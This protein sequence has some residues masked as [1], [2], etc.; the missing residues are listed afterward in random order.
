[1]GAVTV[2][3]LQ[4]NT[5]DLNVVANPITFGKK[6]NIDVSSGDGIYGGLAASWTVTN[7]GSIQ[8]VT[9]GVDLAS[10]GS[11]LTNTGA[12]AG[13]GTQ[14]RGLTTQACV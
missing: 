1:M 6:T 11:T 2:N 5:Y 10:S 9:N 3:P 4:T 7:N 13:T 12:I 8:G 14:E